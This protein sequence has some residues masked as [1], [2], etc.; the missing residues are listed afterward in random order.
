MISREDHHIIKNLVVKPN[1][2]RAVCHSYNNF[3]YSDRSPPIY[4]GVEEKERSI[5]K[6]VLDNS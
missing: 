2:N 6:F 3:S 1:K 4:L 5:I